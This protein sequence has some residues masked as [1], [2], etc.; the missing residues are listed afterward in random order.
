MR[1]IYQLLILFL[2]IAVSPLQAAEK[3]QPTPPPGLLGEES[4]QPEVTIIEKERGTIEEFR[5][6]G[7]LYMVRIT[8]EQGAPYYLVDLDGDGELES[9]R[10]ELDPAVMVPSWIILRW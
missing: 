5:I 1:I 4:I 8:P 3:N 2:A 9:R 6:R 10:E 7:H